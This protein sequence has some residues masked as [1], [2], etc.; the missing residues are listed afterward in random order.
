[1]EVADVQRTLSPG[2][3]KTIPKF[4]RRGAIIVLAMFAKPKPDVIADHVET[5]LKIGLGPHGKVG[6]PQSGMPAAV[7][8]KSLG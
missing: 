6:H 3:D 4:Q 2:T 7:N 8:L 5:L 1:V